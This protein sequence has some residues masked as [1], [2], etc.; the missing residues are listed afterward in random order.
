MT[1]LTFLICIFVKSC[2]VVAFAYLAF[3]SAAEA[4]E[5]GS[6]GWPLF[7]AVLFFYTAWFFHSIEYN[8]KK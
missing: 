7:K 8:D 3:R 1:F 6:A 2:F 5:L 4:Y